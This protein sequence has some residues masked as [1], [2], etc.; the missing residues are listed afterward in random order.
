MLRGA[1]LL[2]RQTASVS[3]VDSLQWK[4]THTHTHAPHTFSLSLMQHYVC[5]VDAHMP[6]QCTE[7]ADELMC[8][9]SLH[10]GYYVCA[11]LSQ[12]CL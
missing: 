8:V 6:L 12:V 7:H 10:D 4:D 2:V 9:R 5:L 3:P 1:S 11:S